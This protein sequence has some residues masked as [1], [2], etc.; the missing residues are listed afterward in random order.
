MTPAQ[1]MLNWV[2]Y[3]EPVVAIPKAGKMPH[4]EEN[5][6]SIDVRI[7]QSTMRRCPRSSSDLPAIWPVSRQ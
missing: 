6:R 7:S 2:T 1:L 5:A 3:Q 4:I